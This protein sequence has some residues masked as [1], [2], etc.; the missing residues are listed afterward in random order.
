MWGAF[1]FPERRQAPWR[2]SRTLPL[3]AIVITP[4]FPI[5]TK[6]LFLPCFAE[7]TVVSYQ[8]KNNCFPKERN[9]DLFLVFFVFVGQEVTNCILC[10][11][12][13][14]P[15][16]LFLYFY[17]IVKKKEKNTQQRPT[18]LTKPNM[19]TE[20]GCWPWTWVVLGGGNGEIRACVF[21]KSDV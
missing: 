9:G 18:S 7:L 16:I 6:S 1:R 2:F 13:L 4:I 21:L 5:L 20:R 17:R 14:R 12:G 8:L 11:C 3:Q 15:K 10:L 19:F